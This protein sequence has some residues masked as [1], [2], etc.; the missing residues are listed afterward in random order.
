MPVR[1]PTTPATSADAPAEDAPHPPPT[2]GPR[3]RRWLDPER[4]VVPAFLAPA[5][6]FIG[7]YLLWPIV[8]SIEL[9]FFSWNGVGARDYLGFDNWRKLAGDS[10][11]WLAFRNNL[12]LI[13]LSIAIQLPL[14]MA[15]A[16]VLDRLRNRIGRILQ[17]IWFIP[18]LLSTVAVGVLFGNV[19]NPTFGMVNRGLEAIGLEQLTRAWLGEPGTALYA[20]IAVVIWQFVPFYMI[21]FAAALGDL[22]DDLH[23]AARIDGATETQYFFRVALPALRPVIGVAV[24]LSVI[25]SLKYFDVVWVMTQGGPVNATELMATYMFR[26]AFRGNQ[27]GYGATIASALFLT[28][29]FATVFFLAWRTARRRA[30]ERRG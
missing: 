6:L 5:L 19:Y 15:L 13:T 30:E 2:A 12:V 10:V 27:M 18:L 26:S 24:T 16:V 28:V 7:V 4:L 22:S 29:L 17:A 3:R 21:L 20:V 11:F 8:Q 9:S 14:A 23:G 1:Q 25:G